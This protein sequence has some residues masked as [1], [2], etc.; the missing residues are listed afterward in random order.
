MA[1]QSEMSSLTN[2]NGEETQQSAGGFIVSVSELM[3]GN[4]ASS[5]ASMYANT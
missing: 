2:E 5:M 4:D 1:A 3:T